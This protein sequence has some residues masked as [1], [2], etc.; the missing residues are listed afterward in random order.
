MALL[1]HALHG[2]GAERLMAQLASRWAERGAKVNL[3]T[4]SAEETDAYP[5]HD[6]VMRCGLGL[7]GQS[8]TP[9]HGIW[10]NI[11]R[12]R[13][14]R[15]KLQELA[16]E[17]ILS[18][19]DQ[20]NIVAL[21]AA[22]GIECPTWIAEHSDPEQQRLSSFWELWRKR[23]YPIC[24]G[25]VALT[26]SIAGYMS[27]WIAPEKMV[28]IP[29][30]IDPPAQVVA[31][32]RELGLAESGRIVTVGRLSEEKDQQLLLDAW[33]RIANEIPGW[34]LRIVGEGSE[35]QQ[36]SQAAAAIPRVELVGWQDGV[37]SE[38]QRADIFALSSRYEGFPVAML[39]AMSQSACCVTTD[40]TSAIG[41]LQGEGHCL[42]V[43]P[44]GDAHAM[45]ESLLRLANAPQVRLEMGE[46]AR[47]ASRRYSWER[48]GL[49]WDAVLPKCIADALL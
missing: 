34:Q 43:V 23:S 20:M 42:D 13:Q 41:Q 30:A 9:V 1:I 6:D 35:R 4:W 29:P 8:S 45:A 24:T 40:C 21:E 26:Q 46:I 11:Y 47:K 16:P 12:V 3:I 18:F 39:E 19:S 49:M 31:S 44:V 22:R 10:A 33:S 17:F 5:V 25:A 38:Y 14:L 37:W 48:V 36:L 15:K 32:T 28:V 2:G 7:V 27:R